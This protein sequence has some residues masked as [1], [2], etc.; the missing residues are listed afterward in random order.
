MISERVRS[1]IAHA[2]SQGKHLGRPY[3]VF[4]RD[5]ARQMRAEGLSL[6]AIGK[7]LGVNYKTVQRELEAETKMGDLTVPPESETIVLVP[8]LEGRDSR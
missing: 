3:K 8:V 7:A 5:Q 4:R 1:G 2:R 6:R